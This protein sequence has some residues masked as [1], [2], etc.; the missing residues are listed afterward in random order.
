MLT[1]IMICLCF[2]GCGGDAF[3]HIAKKCPS[4]GCFFKRDF[5]ESSLL[6]LRNFKTSIRICLCFEGCGGDSFHQIAKQSPSSGCFFQLVF[7]KW[8]LMMQRRFRKDNGIAYVFLLK[9][10][11]SAQEVIKL[12]FQPKAF[13]HLNKI[14][15][16]NYQASSHIMQLH[17]QRPLA[18]IPRSWKTNAK[19]KQR[20]WFWYAILTHPQS[21]PHSHPHTHTQYIIST[22]NYV[23][24][25]CMVQEGGFW[26]YKINFIQLTVSLFQGSHNLK[27][28]KDLLM[29]WGLRWWRISPHR[30][31]SPSSGC[32]F[33]RDFGE[34]SLLKLRNFKTSIRI[35]LCF[36]G[37]G[38]DSFHQIAKKSPSSGCFF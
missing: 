31:K 19:G 7:G 16:K 10:S 23:L 12:N 14:H 5:G 4:S 32:F 26:N 35:C 1:R 29:F 33:K 9:N 11:N 37:C 2:E 15:S 27:K 20:I 34:S 21:H 17:L 36:E 25:L 38:G 13:K 6:K 30:Q 28:Y 3:P 22:R 18:L 24:F 8:A